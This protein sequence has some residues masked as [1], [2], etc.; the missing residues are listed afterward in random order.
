M[1]MKMITNGGQV[2]VKAAWYLIVKRAMALV[3]RI[4]VIPPHNKK[5]AVV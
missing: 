4:L 3:F 1:K 5:I 2:A